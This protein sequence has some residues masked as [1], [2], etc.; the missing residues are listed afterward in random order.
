[1][2]SQVASGTAPS[3]LHIPA[4]DGVR[5]LAILLVLASHLATVPPILPASRIGTL[6]R[7]LLTPG[8][9]GVDLFFTLSG[10]LITG[11]LLDSKGSSNYFPS[12]YIK[13]FLRIFPLYYATLVVILAVS[14]VPVASWLGSELPSPADRW[15]YFAYLQNWPGVLRGSIP[16]TNAIGHFWSLAVEE[17]FYVVWPLC[18]WLL[19]RRALF[20]LCCTGFLGAL[21]LR[22]TLIFHY[23]QTFILGLT[24][25]RMDGLLVGA[26]LAIALR[27][28]WAIS[29]RF[30]WL[31]AGAGMAIMLFIV[32]RHPWEL[33]GTETY[34]QTIGVTGFAILS[35]AL[36]G[37][38][39]SGTGPIFS[40]RIMRAFGKYSYGIYVLH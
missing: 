37:L 2:N 6:F 36:I 25:S 13:R 40:S 34:M 22:C 19:S 20:S 39:L 1:M 7:A 8:W 3:K 33:V 32:V 17:Q 35:G 30:C 18:V 9:C 11:I 4:L 28:G 38:V 10:F 5:G 27:E 24:T 23:K 14:A 15:A 31:L 12:F 29:S 16:K 21:A 26:A